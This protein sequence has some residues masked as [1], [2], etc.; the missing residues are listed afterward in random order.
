[1]SKFPT[2]STATGD[3]I[4]SAKAADEDGQEERESQKSKD[5]K[6]EQFHERKARTFSS[7]ETGGPT[8]SGAREPW[9]W[10]RCGTPVFHCSMPSCGSRPGCPLP[11]CA[12]EWVVR[13]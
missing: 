5:E 12:L 3:G 10:Q 11:G 9:S 8:V 7:E 2:R 4:G 1:M 13:P 6:E